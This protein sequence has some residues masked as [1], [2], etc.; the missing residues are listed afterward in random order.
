MTERPET[1]VIG[2]GQ[3]GLST[4]YHLQARGREALVVDASDRVGDTWRR[5][6]DS[7]RLFTPRRIIG[8]PGSPFPGDRKSVPTKDEV[9]DYLAAYAARHGL[10]VRTGVTVERVV[11]HDDGFRADT[12]DGPIHADHVVV[13]TGK[14]WHPRVPSF[15]S[16][17]G[18]DIVQL[19]SADYQ[20]PSQLSAGRVLVVGAAVSGGD[21]AVETSRTHPTTLCGRV[22][23]HMP[24]RSNG[25]LTPLIP[26]IGNRLLSMR[27][28]LGRRYRAAERDHGQPLPVELVRS[29]RGIPD[30]RLEWTDDRVVG[31]QDGLP[32]TASGRVLDVANVIWCT[33]YRHDY[34]WIEPLVTDDAGWP[35]QVD[36][37]ATGSPGLFFVGL[38][39]Q[40]AYGSG[41]L[42]GVGRDAAKVAAQID[43]GV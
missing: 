37:A 16:E 14:A 25:P 41:F 34:T 10:A 39:F 32:M 42:Y 27:S 13:A 8:L 4:A 22:T 19:H 36:G 7:L 1:L 20:R 24:F 2:A 17:L 15:A 21:I 43:R 11:R 6:Y 12:T 3:A 23:G 5:H 26:F 35:E 18:D 33:G 30:D 40:S 28:P 31:V 29:I 38:P 9:A